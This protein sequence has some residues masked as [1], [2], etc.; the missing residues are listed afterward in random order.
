MFKHREYKL[1]EK[2]IFTKSGNKRVVR[3]F[4]KGEPEGAKTIALPK[5]YIVRKNKKTGVPYLK[6]KK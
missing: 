1:Y 3:F 4:S 5:G 2:E 6:K